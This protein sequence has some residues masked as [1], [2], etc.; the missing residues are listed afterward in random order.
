MTTV[1]TIGFTEKSAER[2]FSLLN[3]SGVKRLLD[4]RLN[5]RSQLAGFA[6]RDDLKYFLEAICHIE[7]AELPDL[8]PEPQMLKDY[9]N[10]LIDWSQYSRLYADLMA[11]RSIERHIDR[12]FLEDGCLLCSEHKPHHCHRRIALEYLNSCWNGS[13]DV[14]HLL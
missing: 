9:R 12:N 4:V 13:L 5:N 3:E 6:K 8:A 1:F 2:F 7:Y 10:K 14:K 11:K